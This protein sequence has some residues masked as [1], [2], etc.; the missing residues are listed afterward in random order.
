MQHE[1]WFF[2]RKHQKNGKEISGIR[3]I[4]LDDSDCSVWGQ[5]LDQNQY[6]KRRKKQV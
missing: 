2:V 1:E 5:R 3:K 6:L 4:M